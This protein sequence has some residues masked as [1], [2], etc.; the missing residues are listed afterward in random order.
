MMKLALPFCAFL[1][2]VF[3][4]C[5]SKEGAKPTGTVPADKAADKRT[6]MGGGNDSI[7]IEECDK[8]IAVYR[9]CVQRMPEAA[10]GPAN[11]GLNQM[12]DSWKQ[13]AAEGAAG[14]EVLKTGCKSVFDNSRQA[15]AAACPDVTWQ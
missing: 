14:A 3:A 15:M 2:L 1:V 4:A 7:G 8:F 6:T 11:D 13:R 10:R 12:I 5:R 9:A